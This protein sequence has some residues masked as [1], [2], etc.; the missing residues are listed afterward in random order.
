LEADRHDLFEGAGLSTVAIASVAAAG[1]G[2][3]GS[4]AAGSEQAGAA[5]SAAQLQYE[6][7]QQALNFQEQ[8]WNTQ[9]QNEAPFL[10]AG[11][12]AINTLSG[13]VSTPGQGLLT[14]WT[15]QF[16]APTAAEAEATPGYQFELGQGEQ[17][18]QNSAA[19]NGGLLA[20]GNLKATTNYAEGL[21]STNYEQ[22][23]NNALTQYQTAYN[24]FQNNQTNE[25]NRLAGVA[26]TGQT[27]AAQLGSQGQAAA[28]NVGNISLTGGAQ[29]GQD[30]QNEAAAGAS[31]YVGASNALSGGL[32]NISSL[33]LL[34]QILQ[35]Q[36]G[37]LNI[38]A[39]N[40]DTALS[41]YS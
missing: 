19:A 10:Q 31:G 14:P 30:I 26:G 24:T 37:G 29:I 33:A 40:G 27:A 20:G 17:A 7:Q 28:G 1:I 4:L 18:L 13:L 22:A 23:F 34:Q 15:Q 39:L 5:K 36:Q 2:A 32:G 35:Q 6:E 8:E 11:K 25:Y 21:A 16:N 12:G 41:P 38:P 3:A 9:Q